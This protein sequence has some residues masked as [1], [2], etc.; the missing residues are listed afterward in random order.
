MQHKSPL[1]A[2]IRAWVGEG[3]CQEDRGVR[4]VHG[5]CRRQRGEAK[6]VPALQAERGLTLCNQFITR[7]GVDRRVFDDRYA[8]WLS[9]PGG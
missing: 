2:G 4:L 5:R 9:P 6:K 1:S 7:N 8:G 3:R